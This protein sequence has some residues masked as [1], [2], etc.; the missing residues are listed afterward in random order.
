MARGF[1]GTLF[2]RSES[3]PRPTAKPVATPVHRPR[4]VAK[5]QPMVLARSSVPTGKGTDVP[6]PA[7]SPMWVDAFIA[8]TL[9][10]LT[11]SWLRGMEYD[12]L[13]EELKIIFLD[14][15]TAI[16]EGVPERVARQMFEAPSK[17]RAVHRI[18]LGPGYTRGSP[19]T[20]AYPWHPG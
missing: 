5:R 7:V 6:L 17:G 16:H 10:Y 19:R 2:D 15:F 14:G 3:R 8:G 9:A 20:A 4:P 18:L 11:S 12:W 1:F 13:N